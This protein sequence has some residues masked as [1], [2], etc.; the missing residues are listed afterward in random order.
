MIDTVPEQKQTVWT[1]PPP[2]PGLRGARVYYGPEFCETLLPTPK[3]L[4]EA[5]RSRARTFAA[6]T[7]VTPPVGEDGLAKLQVLLGLLAQQDQPVE[8]VVNDWGVLRLVAA[9]RDRCQPVLG[10]LMNKMLRD[11][12][13]TPRIAGESLLAEA[14]L[15]SQQ[16]ALTS[17]LFSGLLRS[18][19]IA[20]VE[21]DNLY[22][23]I[24]MDFDGLG[25]RPSLH[26]PFGFV[27]SGPAC[28]QAGM[29]QPKTKK[30][31]NDTP[32]RLECQTYIGQMT[33]S[34]APGRQAP[35]LTQGNT[36]FYRQ[37]AA[38]VERGLAWAQAHGARV[39]LHQTPFGEGYA[40][41][42]I[43]LARS[44]VEAQHG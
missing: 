9:M 28:F 32:C 24:D 3:A 12:R 35:L 5:Y 27:A 10:R 18:H 11:P 13:I 31:S 17:Q 41:E 16:S 25:L 37:D 26:V 14:V 42:N 22:Q 2:L 23:G 1:N 34:A 15:A 40:T 38:L 36:V 7:F 43:D 39:V 29:H 30:F 4:L 21:L 8:V 20:T 44:W 19:G 6:F 33:D